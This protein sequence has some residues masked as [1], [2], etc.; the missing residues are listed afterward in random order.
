MIGLAAQANAQINAYVGMGAG[1]NSEA[2][3]TSLRF[4]GG[5]QPND[6]FNYFVDG[7]IYFRSGP[8]A[9]DV[10]ASLRFLIPGNDVFRPYAYTGINYTRFGKDYVGL[11]AGLGAQFMV[12]SGF[13]FV[14]GHYTLGGLNMISAQTGFAYSFSTAVR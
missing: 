10:N 7:G 9:A 4:Y 8:K 13:F 2:E 5:V 6:S 1:F 14:R 11:N 12:G 3:A